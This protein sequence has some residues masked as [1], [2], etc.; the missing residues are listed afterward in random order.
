MPISKKPKVDP[1]R[2]LKQGIWAYFLLL[3]F[4]GALRKWFLQGLAT[5]LL[6][7]RDPIAIWL[8]LKCWQRDLLPSSIYLIG[9]VIIG[10]ISIF[11]AVF[12]GHGN[13]FVALFGARILLF[14]FPLIFVIGKIFTRED[15]INIGKAT[16]LITI[17]MT[18][19]I[20]MQ[21]YSPQSAWV[22]RGV[23]GDMAGAGYSG[24]MGFFRPPA[25]F[26]FTTGT[27]SYYG[28][29]ACFI[30]YFWFDLKRVNK[31]ILIAATLAM[32]A[33][34]P[35]S[36][37]RTVLFQIGVTAIFTVLAVSRKP[38]YIGKL[39]IAVV[40]GITILAILAQTSFFN[41]ATEAFT[42][43][44]TDA[45]GIE[46]GLKGTLG[47]RF[48]GG[49]VSALSESANQPYFG[50]G[51]GMGTNVGSMLL[52]GNRKFLISEG[53]WGRELGEMGP[54]LGL[55]VIFLRIGLTVKIILASYRKLAVND[56]LPWLLL[57]FGLLELAQGNWAQ[58]TY[59]GFSI[60][61]SGLMLASLNSNNVK[62]R[63]IPNK[64][65]LNEAF[66]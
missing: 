19:L 46:G 32:F 50:Y 9:M 25:T 16:L 51:T 20:A 12:L 57:S 13:L 54:L 21:F 5:P 4:E 26:S 29:A 34:V 1:N 3:I 14:H 30:F 7:I 45:N 11:T 36:I 52:S 8:V 59:L 27:S 33:A 58:P 42:S 40:G 6:I 61:I 15:V 47:D 31:L 64:K 49:L 10:V 63:V 22:N 43:R 60:M 23:G 66:A 28:F 35:L 44:F 39:L 48:L 37:S 17:P 24:A 65:N 41:Q 18:I 56:F 55:F 38:Q 2:I 53:E 62:K